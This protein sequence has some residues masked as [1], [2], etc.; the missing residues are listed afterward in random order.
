[1]NIQKKEEFALTNQIRK[2]SV[3]INSNIAKGF[4][5]KSK[6]EKINFYFIS[7]GSLSELQNQ[8]YLS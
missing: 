4:S 3:S 6:K 8:L 1:M 7:K 5:R 2:C